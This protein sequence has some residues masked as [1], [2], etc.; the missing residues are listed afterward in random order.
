M[1]NAKIQ[2]IEQSDDTNDMSNLKMDGMYR[3]LSGSS[4][5]AWLSSE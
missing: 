1:M 3:L 4:R 5:Y 2:S